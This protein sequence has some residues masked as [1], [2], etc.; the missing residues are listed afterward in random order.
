MNLEIGSDLILGDLDSL[1][2]MKI[3]GMR[4]KMISH[5]VQR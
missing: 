3:Q 5:T 2:S 1:G 4:T